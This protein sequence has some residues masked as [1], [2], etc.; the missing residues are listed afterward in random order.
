MDKT[1]LKGLRVLEA[2]NELDGDALTIDQIAASI[3]LTRSNTHRTLQT[4]AHAGYILRDPVTGGYRCSLKLFEMGTRLL[5]SFDVRS[6]AAPFMRSL[7]NDTAE[8]VH[9]SVLEGTDVVY[10]DKID[11]A[12]PIRAYS[13]IGGRAPAYAVA[14][15]KA[16]LAFQPVDYL[17]YYQTTLQQH[18]AATHANVDVLR[19]EL[20]KIAIKGYACN[21]GEWRE[22][23]GGVASPIFNG[24]GRTIAA[25]GI[26]GPLDRLTI[27]RMES[28]APLVLKSAQELSRQ[29]GFRGEYV[30]KI[31]M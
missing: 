17:S 2:I 7:A 10:I 13:A 12:Q 3:G 6:L 25:L 5:A 8:T 27:E 15:G 22:N 29:L 31:A 24:L 11:S 16:L 18:T 1:L 20:Q 19:Q 23:V 9:L 28:V 14:T 21:R 30:G 4:L 26:S